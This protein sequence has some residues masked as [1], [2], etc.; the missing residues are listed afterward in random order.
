[1]RRSPHASALGARAQVSEV[2]MSGLVCTDLAYD[3]SY[4]KYDTRIDC[5]SAEYMAYRAY[6]LSMVAV[7]VIGYPTLVLGLLFFYKV[8]FIAARKLRRAKLGAFLTHSMRLETLPSHGRRSSTTVERARAAGAVHSLDELDLPE[9]RYLAQLH[10]VEEPSTLS[11]DMLSSML[12]NALNELMEEMIDSQEIAV[13]VISWDRNSPDEDERCACDRLGQIFMAYKTQWW[14]YVVGAARSPAILV[15]NSVECCEQVRTRGDVAQA[16]PH[17]CPL[18]H[19]AAVHDVLVHSARRLVLCAA[20]LHLHEA[21]CRACGRPS[22]VRHPR[23][24]DHDH[25]LRHHAES[26]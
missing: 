25:L 23:S 22:P 10:K 11:N 13:P 5:N 1:M 14:M 6:A 21:V 4:L 8:P 26:A 16:R 15:P 19:F 24:H 7:W 20:V 2:V 3:G 17:Q 9:L 12:V 18:S